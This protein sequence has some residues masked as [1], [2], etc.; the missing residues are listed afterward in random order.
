MLISTFVVLTSCF[1]M[2]GETSGEEGEIILVYDKKATFK[3]E[4]D[5]KFKVGDTVKLPTNLKKSFSTFVGWYT[6]E[7]YAKRVS[8]DYKPTTGGEIKL[9]A[10]FADWIDLEYEFNGGELIDPN[11][12]YTTSFA[13]G[14]DELVLPEIQKEDHIFSSWYFDP[15]FQERADY[16]DIDTLTYSRRLYAKWIEG[17]RSASVIYMDGDTELRRDTYQYQEGMELSYT[18]REKLCYTF[19]GWYSDPEFNNP[20][21][22]VSA[23]T[24][25]DVTVYAKYEKT[26]AY[27]TYMDG[28]IEVDTA[29]Y[30]YGV[31]TVLDYAPIEKLCYTFVG[32]YAEPELQNKVTSI[33]ADSTADIT[34]YAKYV[35]SGAYVIY[36]DG[37]TEVGREVYNYDAQDDID[38]EA[39]KK[40]TYDFAGWFMDSALT[41]AATTVPAAARDDFNV[42]AKYD[43]SGVYVKY[44]DGDREVYLDEHRYGSTSAVSYVPEVDELFRFDGWFL[45]AGFSTP[46]TELGPDVTEDV[47]IYGKFVQIKAYLIYMDGENELGRFIYDYGTAKAYDDLTPPEKKHYRFDGWYKDTDGNIAAD[48]ITESTTGEIVIYAKY[49]EISSIVTYMNGIKEFAVE[50]YIYGVEK[51]LSLSFE[52]GYGNAIVGWYTDPDLT[53][54]ITSIP[55]DSRGPV[56]VYAKVAKV[57]GSINYMVDGVL[58]QSVTFRY[59]QDNYHAY[60]PL[61][62]EGYTFA[63]WY[64][65]S[66]FTTKAS[67]IIPN[68]Q[69]ED[70]TVYAK[71]AKTEIT[72]DALAVHDA[73]IDKFYSVE[74]FSYIDKR[75]TEGYVE[76]IFKNGVSQAYVDIPYYSTSNGDYFGV[77]THFGDKIMKDGYF[78]GSGQYLY[79]TSIELGKGSTENEIKILVNGHG[80]GA[81]YLGTNATTDSLQIFGM[82]NTDF[83]SFA[84]GM[85]TAEAFIDWS[86]YDLSVKDG[87]YKKGDVIVYTKDGVKMIKENCVPLDLGAANIGRFWFDN[88]T[89]ECSL[90]L[91][92]VTIGI[93]TTHTI[94]D[95]Q[96]NIVMAYEPFQET[97]LPTTY[98]RDGEF[99]GWYADPEL[100]QPIT[101]ISKGHSGVVTVYPKIVKTNISYETDGG[102]IN[103]AEYSEGKIYSGEEV[104]IPT[105]ITKENSRFMGWYTDAAFQHKA[106]AEDLAGNVTLYAFWAPVDASIFY[107]VDGS[108][109]NITTLNKDSDTPITYVPDPKLG[110]IF[111]GWYTD[112]EL[113]VKADIKI[114]VGTKE[115]VTLYA[116][117]DELEKEHDI[118]ESY[119][120][121]NQI[122]T[123]IRKELIYGNGPLDD[124]SSASTTKSY[125]LGNFQSDILTY[126]NPA[127]VAHDNDSKVG[128][129]NVWADNGYGTT[130][131]EQINSTPIKTTVFRMTFGLSS[132]SGFEI[133]PF[134][135]NT[136]DGVANPVLIV[137]GK[138]NYIYLGKVDEEH[139]IGELKDGILADLVIDCD[140]AT[141]ETDGMVSY[142]AYNTNGDKITERI[143]TSLGLDTPTYFKM[144]I[145]MQLDGKEGFDMKS[146][147]GIGIGRYHFMALPAIANWVVTPDGEIIKEYESFKEATLPTIYKGDDVEWYLDAELTQKLTGIPSGNI[148]IITVYPKTIPSKDIIYMYGEERLN[149]VPYLTDADTPVSYVP[150][151]MVGY[152]FEGWYMDKDFTTKA[153][154]FIPAGTEDKTV[155]YANFIEVDL[156]SS[157]GLDFQRGMDAFDYPSRVN[158]GDGTVTYSGGS[159][160]TQN[161]G[162]NLKSMTTAPFHVLHGKYATTY[163]VTIELA[164]KANTAVLPFTLGGNGGGT[165]ITLEAAAADAPAYVKL[166]SCTA[167]NVTIAELPA[168]GALVTVTFYIKFTSKF[169]FTKDG[170]QSVYA[171]AYNTAGDLIQGGTDALISDNEKYLFKLTGGAGTADD[172]ALTVGAMHAVPVTNEY[173][174]FDKYEKDAPVISETPSVNNTYAPLYGE[175]KESISGVLTENKAD[176]M[177][178]TQGDGYVEFTASD[179]AAADFVIDSTNMAFDQ[180]GGATLGEKVMTLRD[181]GVEN[182]TIKVTLNLGLVKGMNCIG[183]NITPAGKGSTVFLLEVDATGNVYLKS[184]RTSKKLFATLTDEAMTNVTFYI[185]CSKITASNYTSTSNVSLTVYAF[186]ADGERVEYTNIK[187]Q[188]SATSLFSI[189]EGT[190]NGFP[191]A[192]RIGKS[193]IEW[194]D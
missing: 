22:S 38:L 78:C 158:H 133:M 121:Y 185:D 169:S 35:K 40:L 139:R 99:E 143:P 116:R 53:D 44:V 148:G 57:G 67:P 75:E 52:I 126:V 19:V 48:P 76:Y 20:I 98:K 37:D 6:T 81:T 119:L 39:P 159:T 90:R 171:Y 84:N 7:D 187:Y 23:E 82:A 96:G 47:T 64:A 135:L 50:D 1:P 153:P 123:T 93:G 138:D 154:A 95:D 164:R 192:I 85:V 18:P 173:Q 134:L 166:G 4:F 163:K 108:V 27:I 61:E 66:K 21:T 74:G 9:Y 127:K 83:A 157:D 58:E 92:K 146:N 12:T 165:Y 62:K 145:G 118:S 89:G 186:D 45:D 86:A 120:P 136:G 33:P 161:I 144:H 13:P 54:P 24:K 182:P 174:E 10:R 103:D 77:L 151:P 132:V 26:G 100:T 31:E 184:S 107:M 30:N 101:S 130:L 147:A 49:T 193:E 115:D 172:A 122:G 131:R 72:K 177:T 188:P 114:A 183:L 180:I 97:T 150:D 15:E 111:A 71:F 11:Q 117:F 3:G 88:T 181:Q 194:I 149:K 2:P 65:D 79:K 128:N 142:T 63:G 162:P 104:I 69:T 60:A 46:A 191:A 73:L 175:D 94:V 16:D 178:A 189:K 28:D 42:Y 124:N 51:A 141:I 155:L 55:A 80:G 167:E 5:G 170:A 105:D 29:V 129:I 140:Y 176:T 125:Y 43:K 137:T 87:T 36:M 68:G 102:T 152:L 109:E 160:G 156:M 91:G 17:I 179:D 106:V 41:D 112:A 70:V 59:G 32:W 56:V 14:I 168:D 113:K 25:G 190:I 110:Y 34:L 8:Y